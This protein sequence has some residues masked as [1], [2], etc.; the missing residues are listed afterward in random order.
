MFEVVIIGGSSAGLSAALVLGRAR[1]SALVFDDGKPCNR[2]SHASHGF[3]TRDGIPPAEL[4]ALGRADL[5]RYDTIALQNAR[6]TAVA[7]VDGG[8]SI[9]AETGETVQARTL[10]LA[11]GI[12]DVLP[13]LPGIEPLWGASVFH[14]PY[15]DGWEVRDQPLVVYGSSNVA[16]HK[17]L[18]L[19]QWTD[20]LTLCTGG[21]ADFTDD[22]R[23]MLATRNVRIVE[24]P[25]ARLEAS[26]DH[27]ER[28][29]FADGSTLETVAMFVSPR[30]EH[31]TTFAAD[32]G[33]ALTEQGYV[34]ADAQGRTSVPGVFA[35]GDLTSPMRTVANSVAQG[36]AAA[37]AINIDLVM[38]AA[39]A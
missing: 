12:K 33:C 4:L 27:L 30:M 25:V 38:A 20:K 18:L 39:H 11:T 3:L 10:L 8:F 17:A 32:L 13:D 37:A 7:H 23:A 21:A 5:A 6:V 19:T 29:V 28:I 36:A 16:V 35:A 15:C 31:R 22:Q 24:Q 34:Q 14:C 9:Q 1:R 2:F 26:G